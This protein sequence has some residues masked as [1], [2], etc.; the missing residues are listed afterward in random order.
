M[1]TTTR[2]TYVCLI[3]LGMEKG[4]KKRQILLDQ[5]VKV[6]TLKSCKHK[7]INMYCSEIVW[8]K[9]IFLNIQGGRGASS[10]G[11]LSSFWQLVTGW[12]CSSGSE[13]K[14][15]SVVSY[16]LKKAKMNA[17]SLC[18]VLLSGSTSQSK[19]NREVLQALSPQQRQLLNNW[20]W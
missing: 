16:I 4:M 13:S 12:F 2:K 1:K 6:I 18:C 10:R 8:S 9:K 20:C 7:Q 3:D 11:G 15:S 17:R 14:T 5:K 19:S